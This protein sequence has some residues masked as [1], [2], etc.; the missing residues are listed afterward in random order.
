MTGFFDHVREGLSKL[1]ATLVHNRRGGKRLN[2]FVF[3]ALIAAI[4]FAPFIMMRSFAAQNASKFVLTPTEVTIFTGRAKNPAAGVQEAA[5]QTMRLTVLAFPTG[6][7]LTWE[8]SN[9]GIVKVESGDIKAVAPGD[10]NITVK[11]GDSSATCKVKVVAAPTTSWDIEADTKWYDNNKSAF[12]ITTAEQLAGLAVLVKSGDNGGGSSFVGKTITLSKEIDLRA[13]EWIAIGINDNGAKDRPFSGTFDGNGHAITG[14]YINNTNSTENQG[15][16]GYIGKAGAVKNLRLSGRVVISG[17]NVG[18]VAG[19][20]HGAVTN[21]IMTGSVGIA[22]NVKFVGGVVGVNDVNGAK[23]ANSA[24][25]G[26][27]VGTENVGGVVGKNA[28]GSTVAN[29]AMTGS[30]TC[31]AENVGGVVGWNIGGSEVAN[32]AM[33][34]SVEGPLRGVGG[35]LGKNEGIGSTVTNC[36]WFAGATTNGIGS[37]TTDPGATSFDAADTPVTTILLDT[38]DRVAIINTSSDMTVRTCPGVSADL[39]VVISPD[40]V[41]TIGTFAISGDAPTAPVT[42]NTL[43]SADVEIS[44]P[45]ASVAGAKDYKAKVQGR[46]TVQPKPPT[47]DPDPKPAP[48]GSSSSGCSAG[49]GG[50]AMLALAAAAMRGRKGKR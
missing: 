36:G 10:A 4:S 2:I 34:G 31:T 15:L 11:S 19:L 14:L 26:S 23:V 22:G 25:T 40:T 8:S 16:F 13:H 35:V 46:L 33:T 18:G 21:C 43:G 37:P 28:N 1:R 7:G 38:Y 39:K 29:S 47:P 30:V 41:A 27:V 24:M 6:K 45:V 44:A 12:T 9:T 42:F 20:N 50:I 32:S 17:S 49:A 5:P 3:A 48:G